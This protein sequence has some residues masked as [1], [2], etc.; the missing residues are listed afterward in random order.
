MRKSKAE[1]AK[2]RERILERAS[3]P[4]SEPRNQEAGLARLMRAGAHPRR[5]LPPIR[6]QGSLVSQA[7]SQ[8]ARRSPPGL[9]IPNRG[10]ASRLSTAAARRASIY[11]AATGTG[12]IVVS[13]RTRS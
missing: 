1:T 6:F 13:L 7:C 10:E 2:K 3:G 8:A 12:A 5:F 11:P 9:Q 4:V